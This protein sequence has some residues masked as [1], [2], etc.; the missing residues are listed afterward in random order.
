MRILGKDIGSYSTSIK[1]YL[2]AVIR[3]SEVMMG[4]K[5]II[6]DIHLYNIANSYNIVNMHRQVLNLR[7]FTY[8]LQY[9]KYSVGPLSST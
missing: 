1:S 8:S 4:G 3:M 2:A 5:H 7:K 9:Y 6:I